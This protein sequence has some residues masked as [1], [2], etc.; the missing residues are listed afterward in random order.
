MSHHGAPDEQKGV[1]P[2]A[3]LLEKGQQPE[4]TQSGSHRAHKPGMGTFSLEWHSL[5]PHRHPSS[6]T[7][8][9]ALKPGTE[10]PT[11]P[12]THSRAPAPTRQAR[13]W[14]LGLASDAF[15]ERAPARRS[16]PLPRAERHTHLPAAARPDPLA[17][18]GKNCIPAILPAY[19]PFRI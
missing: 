8:P 18:G 17:P 14:V 7:G 15:H 6:H 10:S 11:V 13:A 3:S 12:H 2:R 1:S 9:K 19:L 16:G 4:R 5:S